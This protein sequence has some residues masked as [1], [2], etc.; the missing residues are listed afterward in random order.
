MKLKDFVELMNED[1]L[2]EL[3]INGKFY[4][5]TFYKGKDL[6]EFENCEIKEFCI[7]DI[8]TLMIFI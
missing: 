7:W 5:N 4:N 8:Q 1:D 3:N 6:A 2:F